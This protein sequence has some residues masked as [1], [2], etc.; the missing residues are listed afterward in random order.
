MQPQEVKSIAQDGRH[1]FGHYALSP[2]RALEFVARFS[3]MKACVEVM[4]TTGPDHTVFALERDTP[5]D[6][7]APGIARLDLF[8]QC[9]S[10]LY[11][12]MRL[13]SIELHGFLIRQ[14]RKEILCISRPD[15][16][17]E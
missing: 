13:M 5:A 3:T 11:G 10:L 16:P 15:V 6:G 4:E 12:P 9:M 1:C 14:R 17:Q 8:D 2:K 7:L